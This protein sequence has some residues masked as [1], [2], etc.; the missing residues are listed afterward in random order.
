MKL[1][2]TLA[3]GFLLL[4]G[5]T[6]ETPIQTKIVTQTKIEYRTAPQS[7]EFW[8]KLIDYYAD[9]FD[10]PKAFARTVFKLESSEAINT[11]AF[12]KHKLKAAKRLTGDKLEQDMLASA[13]CPFQVLG[14][15]A[16]ALNV[17]WEEIAFDPV[18]CT[19]TA[20]YF[21]RQL[22]DRHRKL[23]RTERMR[24]MF[25]DYYGRDPN[26]RIYAS[27]G[28]VMLR[29]TFEGVTTPRKLGNKG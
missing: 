9:Q 24:M 17:H 19:R 26:G 22:Q 7:K 11:Y 20:I 12:N 10:V 4:S 15:T 23:T 8:F 18:E 14:L 3:A 21:M 1:T 27:K 6:T 25:L 16:H 2:T 29:S 28:M 5:C 13:L